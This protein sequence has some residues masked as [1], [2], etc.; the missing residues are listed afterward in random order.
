MPPVRDIIERCQRLALLARHAKMREELTRLAN[1]MER[2]AGTFERHQAARTDK[3][4][5]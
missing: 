2:D 5:G 4:A 1:E 3:L